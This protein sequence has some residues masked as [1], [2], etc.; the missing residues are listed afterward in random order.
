MDINSYMLGRASGKVDPAVVVEATEE[1][2]DEHID[3]TTGYAVDDTLSIAGAAADAKAAGGELA[4]VKSAITNLDKTYTGELTFTLVADEYVEN[5]TGDFKPYGGWSRTDYIDLTGV[6]DFTPNMATNYSAF[7][8]SDKVYVSGVK[9]TAN[10][11]VTVP[12][13]VAYVAISATTTGMNSF[14]ISCTKDGIIKSLQDEVD[15]I[16]EESAFYPTSITENAYIGSTGNIVTGASGYLASGYIPLP[17]NESQSFQIHGVVYGNACCAIYDAEYDPLLVVSESNV[18]QYGGTVTGG[19]LTLTIPYI[20]GMKYARLSTRSASYSELSDLWAKGN[21]IAG[22]FRRIF[23]VE[24][25]VKSISGKISTSIASSKVLV[26]GDSIST[27]AYGSYKKWVTDLKEDGFFPADVENNSQHAT[28]FVARYESQPNDF[29]TRLKAVENPS[30]YDLVIVFGGINDYI[31]NIPMGSETGTDYTVSF[32]PAVN[33]F[34]DYLIQN[35]TQARI[36]VLLPLRTYATWQNSVSEYQQAYGD[37][38]KQ[39]AKSYCLPV[40]NLTEDSGFCPYITAFRDMW[41]LIPQGYEV[42]DGVHPNAEYEEKFLAP[43]IKHFLQGL[44]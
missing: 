18:A 31:Q 42:A 25:D 1:W 32:K 37:Y 16:S 27:D 7:Y 2:L 39:V 14:S 41:T 29:I 43:M 5:T 36:C 4:D 15:Y 34:F 23:N 13:G 40:L 10:Q 17:F 6:S 11:K 20:S 30:E 38:I 8:D 12:S 26:I 28:G 9:L 19:Y 24:N 33:E 22:A 3:P 21:T 35:F 44:M